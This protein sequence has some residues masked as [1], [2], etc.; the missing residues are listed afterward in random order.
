MIEETRLRGMN[1]NSARSPTAMKRKPADRNMVCP[2]FLGDGDSLGKVDCRLSGV[3]QDRLCRECGGA[4]TTLRHV[5]GRRCKGAPV[6]QYVDGF[7]WTYGFFVS[8]PCNLG[9]ASVQACGPINKEFRPGVD[10]RA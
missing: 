2:L 5:A 7:V 1:I 3:V 10:A 8:R 4:C 9:M 6:R